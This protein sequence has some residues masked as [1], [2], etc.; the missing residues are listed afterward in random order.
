LNT[1]CRWRFHW[2]NWMSAWQEISDACEAWVHSTSSL[3]AWTSTSDYTT[4]TS[5][6]AIPV[7][8]FSHSASV[9]VGRNSR[10][11]KR[12]APPPPPSPQWDHINCSQNGCRRREGVRRCVSPEALL[13]GVGEV[14]EAVLRAELLVDDTHGCS[15][16]RHVSKP[17]QVILLSFGVNQGLE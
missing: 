15:Q 5:R 4:G 2:T 16:A 9:Q 6:D 14:E 1:T 8:T 13:G 3:R 7:S 11:N 10:C 17:K 12:G